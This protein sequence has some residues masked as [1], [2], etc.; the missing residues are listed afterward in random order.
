MDEPVLGGIA[1]DAGST[2]VIHGTLENGSDSRRAAV[3]ALSPWEPRRFQQFAK[4]W[5]EVSVTDHIDL[6]DGTIVQVEGSWAG[7]EINDAVV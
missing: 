2:V 3:W 7:T 4:G 1:P 5:I 6:P